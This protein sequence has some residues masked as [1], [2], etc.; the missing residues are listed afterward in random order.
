VALKDFLAFLAKFRPMLLKALLN[1][2]VI[3][4]Q[5]SAKA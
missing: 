2:H 5:L 3:A 4:Q 1:G